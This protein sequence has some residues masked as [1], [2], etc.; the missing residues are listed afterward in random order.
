MY[1]GVMAEH[2]FV[3][4]NHVKPDWFPV[5]I[6]RLFDDRGRPIPGYKRIQRDDTGDTL[7]VHS[8]KYALITYEQQFEAFDRE[9]G[10][11]GLDLGDMAVA[12]DLSH[13][14]ARCFR[15]YVLP[16]YQ[17]DM[18][19]G[20]H[21]ALRFIMFGSYDG[22]TSFHGRCGGYDFVCANTSVVGK[23]VLNLKVRHTGNDNAVVDRIDKAVE[24][25]VAAAR[26]YLAER[27]RLR[28][29][30]GI[31][32]DVASAKELYKALPQSTD[33][34]VDHLV[35][36]FAEAGDRNLWG[37]WN[38]LTSWS[39]HPEG[40]KRNAAQVKTDREKRVTSLVEGRD[41][42]SFERAFA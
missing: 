38:T 7:A 27:E 40:I 36:R 20:R 10:L 34:L 25:L 30:P 5:T 24:Q 3:P 11:S 19:N 33:A 41:W 2:G 35:A 26:A 22:S 17:I 15:Q 37:V 18:P 9:L 6:Q 31:H 42:Q 16:K 13:N 8:D 14:G 4:A 28:R 32:V 29:W 39:S 12:T 1:D 21:L 23:D